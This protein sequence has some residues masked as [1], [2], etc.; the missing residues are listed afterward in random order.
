[1]SNKPSAAPRARWPRRIGIAVAVL[2]L[3]LIVLVA[4]APTLL[5]TGPGNRLIISSVNARIPGHASADNI[6]IGWFAGPRVRQ[7]QL[8][9]PDGQPVVSLASAAAPN[10]SLLGLAR[11]AQRLGAIEVNDLT[12]NIVADRNGRT[13]LQAALSKPSA[14]N[15]A[16]TNNRDDSPRDTADAPARLN[17]PTFDFTGS[18]IDVTYKRPRHPDQPDNTELTVANLNVPQVRLAVNDDRSIQAD[19]QG[20]VA[21]DDD[22]GNFTLDLTIRNAVSEDGTVQVDRASIEG[23]AL[24]NRLPIDAIDSIA[25]LNGLLTAALSGPNPADNH[26]TLNLDANLT[27]GA[28]AGSATLTASAPRL[29]AD[30]TARPNDQGVIT[31]D[32]SAV[33]FQLTPDFVRRLASQYEL[34]LAIDGPKQITLDLATLRFPADGQL[35]NTTLAFTLTADPLQLAGDPMWDG[36]RLADLRV[37]AEQMTLAQPKPIAL[38]ATLADTTKPNARPIGLTA[39]ATLASPDDA[40]ALPTSLSKLTANLSPIPLAFLERFTGPQPVLAALIDGGAIDRLN[41]NI[42]GDPAAASFPLLATLS[43]PNLSTSLVTNYDRDEGVTIL[44]GT[45]ARLTLSPQR[46][47]ALLDALAADPQAQATADNPTTTP[48]ASLVEPVVLDAKINSGK[49]PTKPFNL[50]NVALDA[51]ATAPRLVIARPGESPHRINN[52][53]IKLS[54]PRLADRI[55]LDIT[56]KVENPTPTPANTPQ[57]NTQQEANATPASADLA[58]ATTIR[59]LFDDD[60]NVDINQLQFTTDSRLNSL[61][62]GLVDRLANNELLLEPILGAFANVSLKGDFPGRLS[63]KAD[64]PTA[65]LVANAR[66]TKQNNQVMLGLADDLAATLRV[67]PA[68]SEQFLGKIHPMFQDA[69]SSEKPIQLT[70]NKGMTPIPLTGFDTADLDLAGTLDGGVVNMTRAGWLNGSLTDATAAMLQAITLGVVRATPDRDLRT[71]PATFT[72][73]AFTIK[74]NIVDAKQAWVVAEDLAVGFVGSVSLDN[75]DDPAI[76]DMRMGVLTASLI[77]ERPEL[78]PVLQADQVAE[79]PLTGTVNNPQPDTSVLTADIAGAGVVGTISNLTGGLLGRISQDVANSLRKETKYDW[80]VP[81]IAK[82][83]IDEARSLSLANDDKDLNEEQL[84]ERNQRRDSVSDLL[85]A[86]SGRKDD[87]KNND[88]NDNKRRQREP[89]PAERL[90]NDLLN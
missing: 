5:S 48:S 22:S 60:G 69:Q 63:L 4:L 27:D 1:M 45:T 68:M 81:D 77:V 62:I 9:D 54:S 7:L 57:A 82:P 46:F 21:L 2:L 80:K 19:S 72:P 73:M 12:A 53:T 58:S 41:V 56:G 86:L 33:R 74:N 51:T 87:N 55:D 36:L 35:A 70:I 64:S 59:N 31:G 15:D 26:L 61:P 79:L 25:G 85:D 6:S 50:A 71:Y 44:D 13:N 83:L 67:T 89:S 24:L 65:N 29:N 90:L 30:I 49:I 40:D 16:D 11:G 88:G 39:N 52:T 66:I 38:S 75:L 34:D 10:V 37:A 43:A 32:G 42:E 78:S 76:R 17:L 14:D 18:N 23:N 3:V 28:T 84:D 8:D 47:D 20:T